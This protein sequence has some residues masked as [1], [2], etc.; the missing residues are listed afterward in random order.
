MGAADPTS[1]IR[2]YFSFRS[3]DAWLAA[4]RLDDE[5]GDLA[6][7]VE[8]IPIYPTPDVFPNDPGAV[9][10]KIAYMVQ[11]ILRLTRERGLTIRFPGPADPDWSLSHAA[12]LHAERAGTGLPVMLALF[13]KR[14]SEGL[15]LG[16]DA[17]IADAA[18]AAGVDP[19][20]LVAAAHDD[21]LRREA[22]AGWRRAAERDH[23]FGVPSF[24]FAGK[25]YWGQDRMHFLR[26]AV[27]RK[28][29]GAA[30]A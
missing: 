21:A 3:P 9:P 24:V 13:R 8:L 14:F 10:D 2:F 28:S 22:A 1:A 12:F 19:D 17:V 18:R 5:L 11:D 7:P 4:E 15:D 30:T 20:A 25:L 16:E 6:V 29:A 27:I 26:S 23:I